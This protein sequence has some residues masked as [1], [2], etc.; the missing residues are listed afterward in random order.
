M[1]DPPTEH[2][3]LSTPIATVGGSRFRFVVHG[4]PVPQGS[5]NC[6]CNNGVGHLYDVN[7][8][9]L[10]RWR[11]L[12][13]SEA[14]TAYAEAGYRGGPF[15]GPLSLSAEFRFPM[16]PSRKGVDKTAGR[17]WKLSAPDLDKLV[18]ALGDS[19]TDAE[20]IRDD[21]R[22]VRQVVTKTE[23]HQLWTGVDVIIE[24]LWNAP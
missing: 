5:K 12:V 19:L 22:I 16:P 7:A 18:R 9:E 11:E 6:R 23:V 8:H 10:K 13:T 17:I 4:L 14:R 15:D 3:M 1:I 21:A 24:Q 2:S 20:V